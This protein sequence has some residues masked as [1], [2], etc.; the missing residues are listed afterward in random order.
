[1]KKLPLG[2]QDF[3]GIINNNYLY[4]DKT[5]H[6]YNL[7]QGKYYFLSRPRRF[8]KSLLISAMKEI[9]S[10][11]KE[12]F[13][14]LW[15][16]DKYEWTEHP[17]IHIS[18]STLD[19]KEQSLSEAISDKIDKIAQNNNIQLSSKL[20]SGKFEELIQKIEQ[21]N[22]VVILIDEYD[23]PIIDYIDNIEQ[24]TANR[25]TLKNFYSVLKDADSYIH[26]L[27]ITG[28]SKFSKVSIFSD[29]NNLEDITIDE[30][31]SCLTGITEQE[32]ELYFEPYMQK[33]TEK[34]KKYDID[35]Q[36]R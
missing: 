35:I 36:K 7:M 14:D 1:M 27:F 15:I 18:F 9:F 11:N 12:L 3:A 17:V 23:K 20:Y 34:H 5:E 24:A 30:S 29:L 22:K 33:L 21:K 2:M 19:Y 6:I 13:K 26:F 10:G 4:V 8:G 16:Y 31:F 25:E 32:L 28:V